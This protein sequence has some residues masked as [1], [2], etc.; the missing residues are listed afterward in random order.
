MALNAAKRLFT[1]MLK[2]FILTGYWKHND[3]P[4][5]WAADVEAHTFWPACTTHNHVSQRNEKGNQPA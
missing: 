2:M 5:T 1:S 3:N 4:C